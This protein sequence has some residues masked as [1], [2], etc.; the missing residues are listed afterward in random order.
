MYSSWFFYSLFPVSKALQDTLVGFILEVSLE[1]R[2]VVLEGLLEHAH[3]R[4]ELFL[5]KSSFLG[6]VLFFGSF[7]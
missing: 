1:W 5:T 4:F 2:C 6:C 7:L 3:Q